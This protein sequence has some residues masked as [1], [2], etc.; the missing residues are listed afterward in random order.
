MQIHCICNEENFNFSSLNHFVQAYQLI[1]AGHLS[2]A[3]VV[4]TATLALESNISA[5]RVLAM[6]TLQ[7]AEETNREAAR[8]TGLVDEI[9][10][11]EST[12]RQLSTQLDSLTSESCDYHVILLPIK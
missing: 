6:D 11:V 7:R 12:V 10:L 9:R 3:R 4:Y 5:F 8:A 1:G 2:Q